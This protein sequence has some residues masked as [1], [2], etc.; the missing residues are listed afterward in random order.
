MS[1]ATRTE[2]FFLI[3]A[4]LMTLPSASAKKHSANFYNRQA[5]VKIDWELMWLGCISCELG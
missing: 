2:F 5:R 3:P 4:G 1:V